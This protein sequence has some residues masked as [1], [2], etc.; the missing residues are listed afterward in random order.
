M[1]D[2]GHYTTQQAA[3]LL[4]IP[5][6]TLREMCTNGEVD[7]A[8][9]RGNGP[10]KHWQIP[11]DWVADRLDGARIGEQSYQTPIPGTDG[12][13]FMEQGHPV[14][15]IADQQADHETP[16]AEQDVAFTIHPSEEPS[17]VQDPK[18]APKPKP[19]SSSRRP[20]VSPQP[21]RNPLSG[22]EAERGLASL[23]MTIDGSEVI[24]DIQVYRKDELE[25]TWEYIDELQS[26]SS[27]PRKDI[28]DLRPD[29]GVFSI[30]YWDATRK[31][32]IKW[33]PFKVAPKPGFGQGGMGGSWNQH[34][35]PGMPEG[36]FSSRYPHGGQGQSSDAGLTAQM[37]APVIAKMTEAVFDR[38][39][40][41]EK[42]LLEVY[43][44]GES[45]GLA[46]MKSIFDQIMA[47]KASE[48]ERIQGDIA[49]IRAQAEE[50]RQRD[51][52]LFQH[53]AKEREEIARGREQDRDAFYKNMNDSTNKVLE[54]QQQQIE[55]Q[56]R[57]S[58]EVINLRREAL[59]TER[60]YWEEL[61]TMKE[62]QKPWE[63]FFKMLGP[64]LEK[65]ADKAET[66]MGQ[67]SANRKQEGG[68]GI[69]SDKQI[70]EGKPGRAGT[71][72][73]GGQRSAEQHAVRGNHPDNQDIP[74]LPATHL[75]RQK[76]PH[77]QH[78]SILLPGKS[79]GG[80]REK[81]G[82][83][84]HRPG[85][86]GDGR[87]HDIPRPAPCGRSRGRHRFHPV[88]GQGL[89]GEIAGRPGRMVGKTRRILL[90]FA[91]GRGHRDGPRR[92]KRARKSEP[93]RR[94]SRRI[95]PS[96]QDRDDAPPLARSC[97][98]V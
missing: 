10:V 32:T 40:D 50:D 7:G 13:E 15:E 74:L 59:E 17:P 41:S 64:S 66:L 77:L 21:S 46:G 95:R 30:T 29:G 37:V 53:L 57:H 63:A 3:K 19:K 87:P 4:K 23:A 70:E 25:G 79:R 42:S 94:V 80:H 31:K 67:I 76:M 90:R 48:R 81:P 24:R 82:D 93:G 6:K 20:S 97:A 71:D 2:K 88:K 44:E 65:I 69:G 27:N 78:P 62:S 68:R 84:L 35:M 26:L 49:K 83:S 91:T 38:Q 61:R 33:P 22:T 8:Y 12:G 92:R 56:K 89:A 45:K 47:D 55:I 96:W 51:R 14:I 86:G 39:D 54:L 85:H 18:P 36:A 16:E 11:M 58:E 5:V 52:E 34:G 1:P 75:Q 9:K 60:R 72:R 73:R 43:H 98:T 28:Q